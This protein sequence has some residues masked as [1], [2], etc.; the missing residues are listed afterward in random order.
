VVEKIIKD[1]AVRIIQNRKVQVPPSPDHFRQAADPPSVFVYN[2]ITVK[3]GKVARIL[4][5]EA[6]DF[7]IKSIER[8]A[9]KE[10]ADPEIN[11]P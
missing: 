6:A 9:R 11:L 4:A 2:T 10:V 7:L 5:L 8:L 1:I 3:D